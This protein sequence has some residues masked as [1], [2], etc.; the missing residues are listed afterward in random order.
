MNQPDF[1]PD[2][3][4]DDAAHSS[5]GTLPAAEATLPGL[6]DAPT[7]LTAE[8]AFEK[9]WLQTLAHVLTEE[10]QELFSA[11]KRVAGMLPRLAQAADNSMLRII[12]V[13]GAAQSASHC[14]RLEHIQEIL[15]LRPDG[16][17][18]EQIE[19]LLQGM[20]ETI[21]ENSAGLTRDLALAAIARKI[22]QLQVSGYCSA[23]DFAQ[24][25]GLGPVAELLQQ[26]VDEEA[27]VAA[28]L[29]LLSEILA[30]KTGVLEYR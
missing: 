20:E 13:A 23:R 4:G 19:N 22:E 30:A 26:T 11:E 6:A 5:A 17:T 15:G 18:C 16:R 1:H 9:N 3:F 8:G 24:L 28:R 25:L 29:G 27:A 7:E 14:Q 2:F 12:G 21:A 10:I